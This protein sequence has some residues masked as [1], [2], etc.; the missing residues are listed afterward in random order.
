MLIVCSQSQAVCMQIRKLFFLN[1]RRVKGILK[2]KHIL[3]NQ[4]F[5]PEPGYFSG[6]GAV[7][8]ARLR[9]HIIY[10]LNNS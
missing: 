7:T 3:I 9:L 2:K 4:G 6:A 8:L 10:L 1:I 5:G